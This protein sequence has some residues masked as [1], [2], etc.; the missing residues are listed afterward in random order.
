MVALRFLLQVVREQPDKLP[1]SFVV[2]QPSQVRICK[3]P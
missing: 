2:I 1:A 3:Q